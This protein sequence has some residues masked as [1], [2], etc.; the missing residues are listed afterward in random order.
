MNIVVH[1]PMKCR[2]G[3]KFRQ[4]SINGRLTEYCATAP[5][6][7]APYT[8]HYGTRVVATCV[9]GRLINVVVARDKNAT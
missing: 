2:D 7:N 5:T 1:K 8:V 9:S 4:V 3:A 6:P